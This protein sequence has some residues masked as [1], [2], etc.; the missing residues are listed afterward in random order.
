MRET[1]KSKYYDCGK[2]EGKT[3]KFTAKKL[4]EGEEYFFRVMAENGIGRSDFLEMNKPIKA[5]VPK[6]E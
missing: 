6:S 2:T 3:T 5:E 1:W 4:K